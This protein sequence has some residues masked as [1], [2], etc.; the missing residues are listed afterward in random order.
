MMLVLLPS[1]TFYLFLLLLLF[2][3]CHASVSHP[4]KREAFD[5]T[6]TLAK[7]VYGDVDEMEELVVVGLKKRQVG[8][9]NTDING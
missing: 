9:R 6:P 8:R 1:L 3:L 5:R 4:K 7:F 2:E